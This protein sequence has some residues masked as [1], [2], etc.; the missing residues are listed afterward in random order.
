MTKQLNF[1]QKICAY[2]FIG[3]TFLLPL[4][5]GS[6]S[7]M[8]EASG[9]FPSDIFS[10][11]I[12]NWPAHSL[13]LFCGLS[14][15]LTSIF[16]PLN[17]SLKTP[18]SITAILWGL[19]IPIVTFLGWKSTY[20]SYI[21]L[22]QSIHFAGIG[23]YIL[24]VYLILQYEKSLVK[25]FIGALTFGV[26]ITGFEGLR[27]Y[28]FGFDMMKEYIAMQAVYGNISSSIKAKVLDSRVYSTMV[29]ANILGGFLLLAGPFAI[30]KFRQYGKYFEP[31]KTSMLIFTLMAAILVI[32][33]FLMTK[34]RGAFLAIIVTI[35][36]LIFSLPMKKLYRFI[37][38]L[39]AVVTIGLGSYYIAVKGRGFSS[40]AERVDYVRTSAKLIGQKPISGHG[41]GGFFYEHMKLKNTPSDESARDPH[42]VALSFYI[43]TGIIG[44]LVILLAFGY[45]LWQL[46]IRRKKLSTLN[47]TILWGQVAFTI[48]A[49]GEITMQS[50]AI[51]ATSALLW[52]IAFSN[53]DDKQAANI[54]Q[55]QEDKVLPTLGKYPKLQKSCFISLAIALG[56]FSFFGNYNY[57]KGDVAFTRFY[58]SM[59]PN[60]G[61]KV[62]EFEVVHHF[63][64]ALLYRGHMPFVWELGGDFYQ[65]IGDSD[66]ALECYNKALQLDPKRPAA[67]RRLAMYYL[68][69]GN[70]SLAQ[71]YL[72]KA[73][74]LFPTNKLYHSLSARKE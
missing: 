24:A 8:P 54:E 62:V 25:Y 74:E 14:L 17:T 48:H 31:V 47:L 71:E 19:G 61:K 29:S 38:I 18:L 73:K 46:F 11:L 63:K 64:K 41:W 57:L 59:S 40:M 68:A 52:M 51:P 66:Y 39:L 36:L 5:F 35:G 37:I 55:N 7:A 27:Q 56:I 23:T 3:I 12:I 6:L 70:I 44:F 69:K 49:A 28:F 30:W 53:L 9:F 65:A 15:V 34:T 33:V 21:A 20:P 67:Y 10:W 13:G 4:K 22:N 45:P 42:N 26:L 72:D 1:M 50:P 16:F 32:P 58:D 43:H 2:F 60:N